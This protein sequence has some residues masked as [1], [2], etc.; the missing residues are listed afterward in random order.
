[1]A[2]WGFGAKCLIGW[3]DEADTPQTVM[4]TRAPEV[5][6][7]SNDHHLRKKTFVDTQ[8]WSSFL[9]VW[10]VYTYKRIRHFD[11]ATKYPFLHSPPPPT[12]ALALQIDDDM[13]V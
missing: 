5:L 1:M 11:I 4:T 8:L 13:M 9:S 7:N 6:T 12:T 3:M 10:N 2:L